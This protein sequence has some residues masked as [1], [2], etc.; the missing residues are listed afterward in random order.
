MPP[1][2]VWGS[3]EQSGGLETAA[4]LRNCQAHG[5]NPKRMLG[6]SETLSWLVALRAN[7][8]Y[9][10]LLSTCWLVAS[11]E[12]RESRSRAQTQQARQRATNSTKL[13]QEIKITG[14]WIRSDLIG[15]D[16]IGLA[17]KQTKFVHALR[18]LYVCMYVC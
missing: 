1:S 7:V 4:I 17:I 14:E 18:G 5:L 10:L 15:F 16:W 11:F 6:L 2:S 9:W 13:N 3:T 8:S 12:L